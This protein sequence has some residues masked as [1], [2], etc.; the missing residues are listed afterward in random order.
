M[1]LRRA[2]TVG[3]ALV[4]YTAAAI[5]Y[6][7]PLA[8]RLNGVPHDA[9]DPL[10]TTW[11]LWW[12]GTQAV[13]LTAHWWNAPMF[14]PATGVLAFSEHM[15]G[16]T[17]ISTPLT[18]LTG[19]PLVGHNVVFIATYA[20]GALAAHF[21]AWTLTRRHD[22]SAIAAAAFA[23]APYR[24]P[25]APHL[26]VLASFWTPLCLGALHRYAESWR[27]RWIALAAAAW[28]LQGL[29]C[30]YFVL[31]LGVLV[32]FW[33]FW[34]AIG[35]WPVRRVAVALSAFAA[36]ALV[37][38]PFLYGY[39]MILRDTYG[40]KRS[41][42]EMGMFS[43]D[44]ASL[45][46]AGED[47][48]IWGWVRVFPRPEADLFPGLTIVL[49]AALALRRARPLT[50]DTPEP[51][52]APRTRRVL[53]ILVGVLVAASVLPFVYGS[54]QLSIGGV[55]LLSIAR[56]D[57]PLSLA[58]AFALVLL[59]LLPGVRGAYG[60]RSVAAF[61]VLAAFATWIFAL[62]P[63][64]T[65]MDERFLYRAPYSW[66]ML[67][68]GF[69]GLRAPA[70]FW[71]MT[72]VCLGA[73]GALAVHRLDGRT[74]RIAVAV[75]VAGLLL[76][77]WP[78]RFVVVAAPPL[79]SSPPEAVVRLDL[80]VSDGTDA[81]ALYQQMFDKRPLYNG[82]SGYAAPHYAAM[83]A[84]LDEH[85]PAILRIVAAG[86]PLGITIDHEGDA[87]GALRA[88]V[89]AFPGATRVVNEAA[90]SS[91]LIQSATVTERAADPAGTA[92]RVASVTAASG[93][94]PAARAI[95]GSMD[96]TWN[97][98]KQNGTAKTF[99]V[100]LAEPSHVSRLVLALG[101]Y[102]S[103]F[104]ARLR[105]AVSRDGS[106][107]E[108]V[109]DGSTALATYLAAIRYP[110]DVPVVFPIDRDNVRVIRLEQSGTRKADWSIAELCVL[111]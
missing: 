67:L 90:W 37:L 108:T 51:S 27:A 81:R 78:R 56:A 77:G 44:V 16:V 80:P 110:K 93:K 69:D 96:T 17:P 10:L 79:R 26:Q 58:L 12:S 46:S 23:F 61:Y 107:W 41:I 66:L 24:L 36:G 106:Q 88:F 102:S 111:R 55:R 19:Q 6:T 109:S 32:A 98:D 8:I 74:R 72:L 92:L 43:A 89:L 62:G 86:L 21:F 64:P 31:F 101:R 63:N 25:Q 57:K 84:L 39:Q 5:A 105:I 75:A 7:W 30:G 13:P 104:P 20:L 83:K 82:F 2:R 47:L 85:D 52:W 54:W 76:D 49:L 4:A 48:L 29:S 73:I 99:V 42:G 95:D 70:R 40:F 35:H 87:D 11:F 100:E 50:P 65:L 22:V 9:G 33:F 68:P 97:G 18:L 1:T 14:L 45:L 71:T 60:R 53:A 3:V 59:A 34:F 15:L 91:Y 103:D 38:A 28:V 94:S